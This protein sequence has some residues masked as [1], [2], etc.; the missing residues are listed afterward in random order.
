MLYFSEKENSSIPERYASTD[1]LASTF[2]H[3]RRTLHHGE[4]A[5][6]ETVDGAGR[7]GDNDFYF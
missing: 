4:T 7:A 1:A 5:C 6:S 3:D 2:C